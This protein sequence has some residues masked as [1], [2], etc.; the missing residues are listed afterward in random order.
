MT[1]ARRAAVE[2]PEVTT[3]ETSP[4]RGHTNGIGTL[5]R[6]TLAPTAIVGLLA[7]TTTL[8][9]IPV[10]GGSNTSV[11][12]PLAAYDERVAN[13][14]SRE[15][16]RAPVEDSLS[17]ASSSPSPTPTV[18]PT[19]SPS[20]SAEPVATVSPTPSPVPEVVTPTPEVV[21]PVET[22]PAVDWSVEGKDT[23]SGW[24]TASVNIRTGPGTEFD[25]ILAVNEG[26]ALTLTDVSHEGWQQISLKSGAGWIKASFLT[27]T[28]PV[29]PVAPVVTAKEGTPAAVAESTPATEA[30]ASGGTCAKAGN[31][32]SGMTQRT[33][34]V[35]RTMC[36]Q[37]SSI[38]S[39]GGY[40]AG[41][42]G[43]HGSGQ[44]IDAMITGDAG[45]E[46]ANWARNNASS[47]GIV[48]VIYAQKIWTSQRS[49]D[50]W[51]SMSDRGSVSANHYDHVHISVG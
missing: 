35:L 30:V 2:A 46:V 40:R 24:S 43:Y 25:V 42:S 11:A 23:G 1:Q 32:E 39:Y 12:D 41:S 22:T 31:A 3:T 14:A 28:E 48:E 37:F 45:W 29:A 8:T 20:P 34:S 38:T 44:A 6:K 33:V 13:R 17:G 10:G 7:V 15:F 51:R 4:R 9:F 27:E 19:P 16:V 5:L 49:G 21:E 36:S 50:G 47:L 26:H 18:T